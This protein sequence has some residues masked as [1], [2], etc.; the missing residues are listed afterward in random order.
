MELCPKPRLTLA[1]TT[2]R[3]P[4]GTRLRALYDYDGGH[5]DE[6]SFEFDDVIVVV[7]QTAEVESGWI[8]GRHDTT[9]AVGVFPGTV[10]AFAPTCHLMCIDDVACRCER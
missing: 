1:A 9:G 7:E 10:S 3:Y 5:A 2:F 8:R 6:L 4:T